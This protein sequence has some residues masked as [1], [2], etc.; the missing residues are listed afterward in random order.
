MENGYECVQNQLV[1]T[2]SSAKV[3][4]V[5][6]KTGKYTAVGDFYPSNVM[7]T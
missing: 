2:N 3:L 4:R 7:P 5:E 1:L 6:E